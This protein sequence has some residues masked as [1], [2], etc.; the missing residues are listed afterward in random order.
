MGNQEPSDPEER[1]HQ[2]RIGYDQ[3]HL[4]RSDPEEEDC[5]GKRQ[6]RKGY[7]LSGTRIRRLLR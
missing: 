7:P 4:L 5:N 1:R 6:D 2:E 3:T